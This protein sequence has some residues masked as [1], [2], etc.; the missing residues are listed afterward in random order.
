M[1][2]LTHTFVA[3]DLETTGLDPYKDTIIEVAA[4]KFQ[5]EVDGEV[6]RIRN[7]EERSMLIDPER[8]LEE[9]ISMITGIS[10]SMLEGKKKWSEVQEKVWTFIGDAII[11]GHNVL[12]DINMLW[13]HGID[14]SGNIALDTFELSEIFSMEAASLNLGFLGKHYGI[15]MESEHRAL[16]DTKLS[17]ELFTHYLGMI[18]KMPEEYKAL[19]KYS[20]KKDASQ[21]IETLVNITQL[22]STR[23][24]IIPHSTHAISERPRIDFMKRNISDYSLKS[25]SGKKDEEITLIKNSKEENKSLLIITNGRKQSEWL[26]GKINTVWFS[27]AIY[28]DSRLYISLN[29]IRT[30][31]EKPLWKRKET[32]LMIK[33][34]TWLEKTETGLIDEL[35]FYGEERTMI[36]LFRSDW[37][38][39]W[40]FHEKWYKNTDTKDVVLADFW[41]EDTLS[42]PVLTK[43]HNLIIRDI[44]D[45]EDVFR[46]KYTKHISFENLFQ[47]YWELGIKNISEKIGEALSY[48]ENTILSVIV[49][50][51]GPNPL[52]PGDFWETYFFTQEALWHRGG[53]WLPLYTKLLTSELIKIW[54]TEKT[55][56]Y[57]QKKTLGKWIAS[58]NNLIHILCYTDP[59][60]SILIHIDTFGSTLT[61]VPRDIKKYIQDCLSF[62]GW[63][64]N[65]LIGYW[66]SSKK[67]QKFLASE[68]GIDGIIEA[69]MEEKISWKIKKI[70]HIENRK[71]V[72][73]TTNNKHIRTIH[74][75]ISNKQW[76]E[77]VFAQ[78]ISGGKW[79]MLTL[80]KKSINKSVLIGTIDNWI[81]E[82]AL[83]ECIDE[84]I[85]MKVP[86]DPPTDPYFLARTI[87]MRNNFEEYS[88]PI[89]INTLNTLI[90]RIHSAKE[91]V[92][93]TFLDERLEKMQW[94]KEIQMELI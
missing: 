57:L 56:D 26:Q 24:Y 41:T 9:N 87:G 78:W 75:E 28:N 3:L 37:Q 47:T 74:Q 77:E 16:D 92:S 31:F 25:L 45:M 19:W 50:P 15:N 21:T 72:I 60:I 65:T 38:E 12:F 79:K 2:T 5:L 80:F 67:I 63:D 1:N 53:K 10:N 61:L 8:K 18:Q 70:L 91:D 90:W 34:L 4:V 43:K 44:F 32:I 83:W 13:T 58:L 94:W 62:Q 49:R 36:E 81:N 22:N 88:T 93:I 59:N 52:P 66:L 35:K 20:L 11:V 89:A 46:R 42:F 51:T 84:V 64:L 27:T 73:L 39:W 7:P 82:S 54:D 14:L 55:Y 48:I 23:N 85:I 6:F 33:L 68:C 76:I 17:M 86:F 29:S 69:P 30:F 40:Y 71:T